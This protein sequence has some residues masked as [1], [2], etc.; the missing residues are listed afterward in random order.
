MWKNNSRVKQTQHRPTPFFFL[1]VSGVLAEVIAI[2][3]VWSRCWVQ[4][5]E[6]LSL[7]CRYVNHTVLASP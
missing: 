3:L 2:C 5:I 1:A 7:V 6:V 4:R